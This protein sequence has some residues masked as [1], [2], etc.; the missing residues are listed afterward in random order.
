MRSASGIKLTRSLAT[1]RFFDTIV[2]SDRHIKRR[3]Q[4]TRAEHLQ[5]VLNSHLLSFDY[6]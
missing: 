5:G 4:D 2:S 6:V 3:Y 1:Q